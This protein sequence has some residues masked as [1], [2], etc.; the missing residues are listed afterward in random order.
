MHVCRASKAEKGAVEERETKRRESGL[1]VIQPR[2][3][4]RLDRDGARLYGSG[5]EFHGPAWVGL[6]GRIKA[7]RY[8]GGRRRA[9]GSPSRECPASA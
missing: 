9:R 5:N 7:V 3:T 2:R 4:A 6:T 1:R 8:R